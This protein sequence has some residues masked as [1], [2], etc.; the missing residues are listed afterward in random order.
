M[1][2]IDDDRELWLGVGYILGAIRFSVRLSRSHQHR[3]GYRIRLRIAWNKQEPP[4]HMLRPISYV[5]E[6]GDI[7]YAKEWSKQDDLFRWIAFIK[8]MDEAYSIRP[9]FHDQEGLHMFFWVF[10][11]PPPVLYEEFIDWV[12]AFD[13]EKMSLNIG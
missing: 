6:L 8:R 4:I 11:N 13:A 1:M 9:M 2:Q 12:E 5:L 3:R 7:E 10:D